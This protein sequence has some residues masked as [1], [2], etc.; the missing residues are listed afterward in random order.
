MTKIGIVVL[1]YNTKKEIEDCLESIGKLKKNDF[2]VFTYLVDNA[3]SDKSFREVVL[4]FKDLKLTENKENLGFSGGNN[5][6]IK[7]A[8]KDNCDW[9]LILN[10]D[11]EVDQNLLVEFLK[12]ANQDSSVGIVGP[13]IYFAKGYEFHKDRYRKDQLGKVIWYAGGK[14]DWANVLASHIGVD[15]VDHGQYDKLK[16]IDFVTG[17]A[18]FVRKEVFEKIGF[19]DEKYFLY[20]EDLEFCQR[21]KKRG[22]KLVF[23]PKAL[24]WHKN[25]VST[26]VGSPLQDYFITRNRL[27]FGFSY[28]NLRSKFALARESLKFLFGPNQTKR[29]AVID[30]YLHRLGRG[31][32]FG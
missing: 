6:G 15:E 23:S 27:I 1:N 5:V 21:A 32:Y 10:P 7:Q 22:I 31:M 12:V 19:F 29:D 17:A 9:V 28:A 30:F 14:I 26:K 16:E 4:K 20:L 13:K 3:S 24:V 2:T 25:A 11:T 8:L 18:M